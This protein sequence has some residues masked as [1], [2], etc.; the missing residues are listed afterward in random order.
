M[1]KLLSILIITLLA[2]GCKKDTLSIPNKL[3]TERL[4]L[5]IG[6]ETVYLPNPNDSIMEYHFQWVREVDSIKINK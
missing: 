1:R 5:W 2:V 6:Y 3:K 4:E